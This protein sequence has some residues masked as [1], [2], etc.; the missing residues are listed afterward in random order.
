MKR[1]IEEAAQAETMKGEKLKELYEAKA[2]ELDVL[3]ATIAELK[4]KL[5]H[6]QSRSSQRLVKMA[7]NILAPQP[8]GDDAS[9]LSAA[10]TVDR[11]AKDAID[12]LVRRQCASPTAPLDACH[13]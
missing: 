5:A 10:D 9:I 4:D 7:A 3:E 2:K 13:F 12:R 11:D 1:S 6:E 8:D